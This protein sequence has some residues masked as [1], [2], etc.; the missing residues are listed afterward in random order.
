[1]E[2]ADAVV[3]FQTGAE[4]EVAEGVAAAES[5]GVVGRGLYDV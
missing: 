5:E 2:V 3:Q 4:C 1:M